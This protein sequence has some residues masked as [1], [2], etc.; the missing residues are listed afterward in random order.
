M[1]AGRLVRL[2]RLAQAVGKMMRLPGPVGAC[3][4]P[5]RAPGFGSIRGAGLKPNFMRPRSTMSEPSRGVREECD[6]TGS[7]C[8]LPAEIGAWC[9]L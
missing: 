8:E 2:A 1:R 3:L 9:E 5:A 6:A 7:S 4:R